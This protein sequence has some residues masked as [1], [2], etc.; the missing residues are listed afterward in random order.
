MLFLSGNIARLFLVGFLSGY[1][2]YDMTHYYIHHESPK[3]GHFYEMKSY[4]N[5]HHYKRLNMGFGITSK[6]W[7]YVYGT[8]IDE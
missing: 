7:D 5:K 2:F 1:I 4:H 6:F 8:Q 3:S